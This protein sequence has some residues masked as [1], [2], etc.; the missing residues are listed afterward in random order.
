MKVTV[1]DQSQEI[2]WSPL[3]KFAPPSPSAA[4][5]AGSGQITLEETVV[6]AGPAFAPKILWNLERS[7]DDAQA[8]QNV[9]MPTLTQD[10]NNPF[11]A[12][13]T[14][15]SVGSFVAY[16][17]VDMD[18]TGTLT[19]NDKKLWGF[20]VIEVKMDVKQ[21]S[22]GSAAQFAAM[23]AQGAPAGTQINS[24]SANNPAINF[25]AIVELTGGGGDMKRGLDQI[26]LG[27]LGNGLDD[28]V[29]ATYENN[30]WSKEGLTPG[31]AFPILDSGRPNAGSGAATAFLSDSTE[32]PVAQQQRELRTVTATD[33]PAVAFRNQHPNHLNDNL[34][35]IGGMQSF[36]AYLVAFAAPFNKTYVATATVD[37]SANYAFTHQVGWVNTN[38]SIARPPQNVATIIPAQK[39]ETA[40]GKTSAPV[41]TDSIA[42]TYDP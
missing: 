38:S 31:K 3:P 7:N 28:T 37:W 14:T 5:L 10:Q 20:R 36:R 15:D 40:G 33:N 24:G 22:I 25:S 30:H 19:P 2:Q 4:V 27:W 21:S 39:V 16:A 32:T 23:A 26:Y 8:L 17:Y 41:W 13:L 18:G 11:K 6:N 34:I 9:A 42:Y 12:V 35:G 1:G 29:Q